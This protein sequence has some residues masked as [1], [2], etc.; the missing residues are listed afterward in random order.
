MV[1]VRAGF[2]SNSSSCSF[3][4]INKTGEVL[5]MSEFAAET[6]FLVDEFLIEYSFYKG[7]NMFDKN[8][9]I[10]SAAR[11]PDLLPGSQEVILGDEDGTIFGHICDYMLRDG[12]H[13]ERFSWD[14]VE[15]LR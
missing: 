5:S 1:K 15:F 4:I 2:V 9:F 13:T 8:K 12:G 7:N 14:F 11:H 3:L 10:E 6:A